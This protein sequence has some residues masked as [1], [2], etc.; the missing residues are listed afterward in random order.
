MQRPEFVA[1]GQ[2]APGW[3]M[4]CSHGDG[5]VWRDPATYLFKYTNAQP[6]RKTRSMSARF[7]TSPSSGLGAMVFCAYE[8][9]KIYN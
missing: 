7:C 2:R 5:D 6:V 3:L 1:A 9:Q 8:V 4:V